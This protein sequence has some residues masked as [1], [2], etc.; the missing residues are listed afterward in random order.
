[1]PKSLVVSIPNSC[2]GANSQRVSEPSEKVAD[3]ALVVLAR[4]RHAL[5]IANRR[6]DAT[7]TCIA[8]VR[9]KF[10]KGGR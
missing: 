3:D 6:L 10:A 9:Q 7:R 4:Y 2:E 8:Q 5:G 1:M